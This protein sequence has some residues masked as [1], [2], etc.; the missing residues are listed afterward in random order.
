MR[1]MSLLDLLILNLGARFT[2][3]LIES[4]LGKG[5]GTTIAGDVVD[6]LKFQSTAERKKAEREFEELG[7]RMARELL[8]LFLVPS[9]SFPKSGLD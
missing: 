6:L 3:L 2:K 9:G 1:D 5:A 4:W 8:P 7:D